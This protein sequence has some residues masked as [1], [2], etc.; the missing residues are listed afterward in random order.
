[1]VL[2]YLGVPLL[3]AILKRACATFVAFDGRVISA[4]SV[5]TKQGNV[6]RYDPNGSFRN[7]QCSSL[8]DLLFLH[9]RDVATPR[10]RT[11]LDKFRVHLTSL[12]G[13]QDPFDLLYD[14]RNQSLH[15]S[16]NVQTIGGTVLNLSLLISLFEI[17]QSFEQ[18]RLQI[19][20]HCRWEA[21]SQ[22]KSPWSFYP[23]Y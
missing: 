3:E 18:H 9:S 1:V 22:C 17:E 7:S 6:K 5:P 14:W 23:P 20:D 12:D 19:L 21:Q 10:L 11:L 16:T 2:A 4:F 13:T 15:G 8:R